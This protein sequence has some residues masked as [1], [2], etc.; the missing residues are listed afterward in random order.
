LSQIFSPRSPLCSRSCYD[1]ENAPRQS[2]RILWGSYKSVVSQDLACIADVGANCRDPTGHR[3]AE[4]IRE[5]L[6][7]GRQAE[8][9]QRTHDT[10]NVI[11]A[12]FENESI[13]ASSFGE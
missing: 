9:I 11:T 12:I 1:A 7:L 10:R 6:A 3:F 4:H 13:T 8:D 2:V 5:T